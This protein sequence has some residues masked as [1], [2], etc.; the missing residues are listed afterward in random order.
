MALTAYKVVI[1][2]INEKYFFDIDQFAQALQK[3]HEEIAALDCDTYLIAI[4]VNE[5]NAEE[6]ISQWYWRQGPAFSCPSNCSWCQKY[7]IPRSRFLSHA[8]ARAEDEAKRQ[9]V[10]WSEG[11]YQYPEE[12]Q[13]GNRS[14]TKTGVEVRSV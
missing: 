3:W 10:D 6:Q 2:E 7:Q 8:S 5:A 4:H 13:D 12:E 11:R 9:Y 1:P 14:A